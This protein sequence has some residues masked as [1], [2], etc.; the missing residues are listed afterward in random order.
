LLELRLD[1]LALRQQLAFLRRSVSKLLKLTP[2][3]RIFW[4]G[5]LENVSN[6]GLATAHLRL[7]GYPDI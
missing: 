6:Q 2:A 1:N 4:V 5:S 7:A 3:D